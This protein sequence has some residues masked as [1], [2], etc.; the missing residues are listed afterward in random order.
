M[1]FLPLSV[2][3][4]GGSGRFPLQLSGNSDEISVCLWIIIC[5]DIQILKVIYKFNDPKLG[6]YYRDFM[7]RI[8]NYWKNYTMY[9]IYSLYFFPKHRT[10]ELLNLRGEKIDINLVSTVIS[11]TVIGWPQR[12][13]VDWTCADS[14]LLHAEKRKLRLHHN[15]IH[16]ARSRSWLDWSSLRHD[17]DI[18]HSHIFG[19]PFQK[20]LMT[21]LSWLA[22]LH[23]EQY[24]M[25]EV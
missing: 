23:N 19:S 13:L 15:L 16:T 6:D 12:T 10:G 14:P 20:G 8:Q 22:S 7:N 18:S 1:W 4:C 11:E 9:T 17:A 25:R 3:R 24:R 2:W 5:Q 21:T